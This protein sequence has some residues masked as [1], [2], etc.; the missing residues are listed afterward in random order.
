M[1]AKKT[2]PTQKTGERVT[3]DA[4]LLRH[5]IHLSNNS[6]VTNKTAAMLSQKLEKEDLIKLTEWFY[7]ARRE[8]H[9]KINSTKLPY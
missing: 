6:I 3:V 7:L 8:E 9:I 1:D 2:K 4:D 5:M